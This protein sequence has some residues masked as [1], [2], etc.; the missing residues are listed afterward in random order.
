MHLNMTNGIILYKKITLTIQ[1]VML[2]LKVAIILK[3]FS[4]IFRLEL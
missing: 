2:L 3:D 4:C 1:G